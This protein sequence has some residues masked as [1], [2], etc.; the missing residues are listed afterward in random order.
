MITATKNTGIDGSAQVPFPAAEVTSIR[1]TDPRRQLI[2][3]K[4]F[5]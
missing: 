5:R 2:S 3:G 1:T 4:K